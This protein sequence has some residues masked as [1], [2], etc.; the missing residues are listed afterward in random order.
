LQLNLALLKEIDPIRSVSPFHDGHIFVIAEWFQTVEEIV[1]Y[2]F[3]QLVEKWNIFYH[4][5]P[6]EEIL[7]FI[8]TSDIGFESCENLGELFLR[9]HETFLRHM[10]E[11]HEVLSLDG[12]CSF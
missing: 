10:S 8:S 3:R 11:S 2:V 4:I 1:D 5:Q 6:E 9:T 7:I 12:S